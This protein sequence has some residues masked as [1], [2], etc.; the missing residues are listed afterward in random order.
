MQHVCHEPLLMVSVVV[1]D[2]LK[3]RIF[4]S[5][6]EFRR[7]LERNHETSG[8]LWI[9]YYKQGS[10]RTSM[11]YAEA[12][13]EA[14]C[15]GWIDGQIRRI[16]ED[17][18]A[19]RYTPRRPGSSWSAVN[20][21]KADKLKAVGRMRPAGLRAFDQRDR[22]RDGSYSYERSPAELPAE[23]LVRMRRDADARAYWQVE[24][25]SYRRTA[26]HWV[27]SAKRPETRERRFTALLADSAAQRRV[28]PFRVERSARDQ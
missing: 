14:L 5:A 23:W 25:P 24:T 27:M 10:G 9:G 7:W 19:N 22:G 6:G 11:T 3:P 17:V 26:S 15:F 4:R 2:S 16:S 21:T 1:A 13:E 18:Y 28:K 8:E 20:V 12:V